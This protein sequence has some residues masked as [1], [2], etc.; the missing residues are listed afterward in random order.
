M[1]VKTFSHM[2]ED[3]SRKL[4]RSDSVSRRI[5]PGFFMALSMILGP[6]KLEGY[7]GKCRAVVKLVRKAY[8]DKF[9]WEDIYESDDARAIVIDA[10][11]DIAHSFDNIERRAEWF[12]DMVNS[13][14]PP[15]DDSTTQTEAEWAFSTEGFKPFFRTLMTDLN[16]AL[17]SEGGRLLI[18][19]R[20]GVEET[21][22]LVEMMKSLAV[23]LKAI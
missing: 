9:E 4:R 12:I 21:V 19:R 1:I 8:G 14:L 15:P 18:T 13:H 20:H 10:L 3:D 23:G 2:L 7:Q 11:T 22:E 17:E 5:L 6:D 16:D